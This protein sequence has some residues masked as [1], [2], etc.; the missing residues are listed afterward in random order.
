MSV[1][2]SNYKRTN[3]NWRYLAIE[4]VCVCGSHS[5]S[6]TCKLVPLLLAR[7]QRIRIEWRSMSIDFN[8]DPNQD[9]IEVSTNLIPSPYTS[10]NNKWLIGCRSICICLLLNSNWCSFNYIAFN[11]FDFS[12]WF[13]FRFFFC[14]IFCTIFCVLLFC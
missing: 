3:W 11:C 6:V 4:S 7:I 12:P 9:L 13:T 10:Q 14:T 2:S 5:H 1:A 8:F